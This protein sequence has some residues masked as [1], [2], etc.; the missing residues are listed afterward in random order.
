MPRLRDSAG[1]ATL[2]ACADQAGISH[3][4]C[5]LAVEDLSVIIAA[6][7]G[8]LADITVGD[9]LELIQARDDRN[10]ARRKGNSFYQL[11]HT[12]GLLPPGAPATLRMLDPRFQGQLTT[13]E[14]IGQYDL[15]CA[16]VRDLL[17]GYLGERQPAIRLC[18][19]ETARLPSRQA[20]LE[21][22]R[23]PQPRHQ[24]A[25]PGP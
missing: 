7:G 8:T 11:L 23:D 21:G 4:S 17:T 2:K 20:V 15:A 14:L 9:C 1:F 16:P 3:D 24:L 18:D 13:A 25:A 12:A 22:P 5:R 10:G 19:A 6:K